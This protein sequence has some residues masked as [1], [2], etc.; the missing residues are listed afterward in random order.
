[1]TSIPDESPERRQTQE[2]E[3]ARLA[4]ERFGLSYVYPLQRMA[5]ANVLDSLSTPEGVR[6][7]VLFPTGF[8]KSVCFQLPSLLLP[9]PTIIVYPLLALMSDQRRSL[10]RR[11]IPNALFRGGMTEEEIKNEKN[12]V[13][14]GKTKIVI[15]N[16]ESLAGS[17][18]LDFLAGCRPSHLAIDEAHCV[19]E[20]GETFRPA[21]LELKRIIDALAA[22]AVSAFTATAS[23]TVAD[24]ISKILFGEEKPRLVTADID[25]PAIRYAIEPTLS[26]LHTLVRL[27]TDKPKPLIVFDNS[28]VGVYR[29]AGLIALRT[30]LDVRYYHAGLERE[31]KKAIEEWFM[32]SAGGV[33]VATCAYG[34]GVDKRNVRT[35]IHFRRPESVEAY[36]Q[37]SGRAA[38][39]GE[40][41]EAILIEGPEPEK[42]SVGIEAISAGRKAPA[43]GQGAET[44]GGETSSL[45]TVRMARAEA[46]KTYS[47]RAGCRRTALLALMGST[48]EGPCSGCD[49]CSGEARRFPEGYEELARFFSANSGRFRRG[50]ALAQLTRAPLE[51]SDRCAQADPRAGNQPPCAGSGLLA[52]W[53]MRDA[54]I[55][56]QEAI[57]KGWI[58]VGRSVFRRGKLLMGEGMRQFS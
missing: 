24:S 42:R 22:P 7:L 21:Y 2:D 16:P 6:Q 40:P 56:L 54:R 37:E 18:L 49:V 44:K 27:V 45:D 50:E 11:G 53:D 47:F 41:A 39:D 29:L 46:F 1:M 25:K 9:G 12:A 55:L 19:S 10:E 3:V 4:R 31:E 26:S 8:G 35:V 36:L 38:R 28:R 15:T 17:D 58:R 57:A 52:D 32:E 5:V 14:S 20:W 48:L 33:L 43:A 51:R 13:R 23:P 30:G 34:L